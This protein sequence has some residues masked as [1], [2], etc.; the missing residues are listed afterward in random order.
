MVKIDNTRIADIGFYINLD[1]RVDRN[2]RMLSQ[3]SQH[4]ITGVERHSANSSTDSGHINCKKSHYEL[5]ERFLNTSHDYLLVLEDDCLFLPPLFESTEK[6]FKDIY[7]VEWDMFWL[8]CRNRRW[9]IPYKN[10]CFRTVSPA[11]TQSYIITRK[12]CKKLITDYPPDTYT[13]LVIDELLCLLMY[14]DDVTYDP[15]KYNF[16]QLDNPVDTIPTVYTSLCYKVALTTQFASYS[17][18]W[19]INVDYER[20]ISSSFPDSNI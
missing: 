17:D 8:G 6:I 10:N 14:G 11:H 12:L 15:N 18:L 7:S 4:N 13:N 2:D 3:F 19:H 1:K 5:Y 16:Y 20:Y 9:P